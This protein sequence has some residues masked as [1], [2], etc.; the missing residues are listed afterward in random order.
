MVLMNV[1][2]SAYFG[3]NDVATHIWQLLETQST[4]STIIQALLEQY[5]VTRQQ[6]EEEV[7]AVLQ[8]MLRTNVL[9]QAV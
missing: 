6:C 1:H 8:Q 3:L 4:F 2:T 5:E 7:K 9:Q